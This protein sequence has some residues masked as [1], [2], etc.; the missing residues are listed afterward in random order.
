MPLGL[1]AR[2]QDWSVGGVG[3]VGVFGRVG[4]ASATCGSTEN[5]DGGRTLCQTRRHGQV[6]GLGVAVVG[7]ESNG[8]PGKAKEGE[9]GGRGGQMGRSRTCII[10]EPRRSCQTSIKNV[11]ASF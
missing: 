4:P 9:R 8:C 6:G 11:C 1:H 10:D 5:K 7:L 2:E 3:L